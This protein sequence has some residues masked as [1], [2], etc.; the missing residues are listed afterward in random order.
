MAP[1]RFDAEYDVSMIALNAM[2]QLSCASNAVAHRSPQR[3]MP[4]TINTSTARVRRTVTRVGG[5]ASSQPKSA[6]NDRVSP[7]KNP[8]SQWATAMWPC[9]NKFKYDFG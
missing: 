5:G 9:G 3:T 7:G 8:C 6:K 4:T 1:M 2:I